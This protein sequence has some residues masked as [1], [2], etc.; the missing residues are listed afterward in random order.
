MTRQPDIDASARW[1]VFLTAI[2]IVFDGIDNQLLG[3][4]TP[5]DRVATLAGNRVLVRDGIAVAVLESGK[6]R[7]LETTDPASE[8]EARGLLIRRPAS[9]LVRSYLKS[10]R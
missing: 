7:M 8:W 2:T 1:L 5:G 6:V 4:V 10:R 3:V 9:P